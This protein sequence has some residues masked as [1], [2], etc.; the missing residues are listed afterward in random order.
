MQEM[1]VPHLWRHLSGHGIKHCSILLVHLWQSWI[2]WHVSS[3]L[4][5]SPVASPGLEYILTKSGSV[6]SGMPV[7]LHRF[8]SAVR[9]R[10]R[11]HC[12]PPS[13]VICGGFSSEVRDMPMIC[14]CDPC[15]ARLECYF[16]WCFPLSSGDRSISVIRHNKVFEDRSLWVLD[17]E[18]VSGPSGPSG[19]SCLRSEHGSNQRWRPQC[20]EQFHHHCLHYQ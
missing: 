19:P 8:H 18:T 7:I 20:A 9:P 14:P 3:P 1:Q 13:S 15:A 2:S 10:S 11:I 6:P 17:D 16:Q 12:R 5:S 4:S